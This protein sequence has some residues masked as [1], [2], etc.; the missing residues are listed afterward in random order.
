VRLLTDLAGAQSVVVALGDLHDAH[1]SS[2]ELFEYLASLGPQRRWLLIGTFRDEAVEAGGELSR[3]IEAASCDQFCVHVELQP[4]ARH[5][6]DEL[7][8]ALLPGGVVE[9]ALLD[10]LYTL[11]LGNPLFAKEIIREARERNELVLFRGVWRERTS[12]S[13]K[14]PARVR[15]LMEMSLA[16]LEAPVRRVLDLVAVGGPETMLA[17]LHRAAAKLQPALSNADLLEAL[18]QA[19]DSRILVERR[20]GYAFRHPLVRAAVHEHLSHHRLFQMSAALRRDRGRPVR[21]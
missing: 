5:H 19:L 16:A 11:S 8:R 14:V 18:D 1:S 9:G 7:A 2:I 10:Y 15:A 13:F 12:V 4:L 20:G 17:D 21:S 3:M 6:C